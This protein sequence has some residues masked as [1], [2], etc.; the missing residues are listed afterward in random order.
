M[1]HLD[2]DLQRKLVWQF[3][4]GFL[5][6]LLLIAYFFF[7]ILFFSPKLLN[8][9]QYR[10]LL[11]FLIKSYRGWVFLETLRFWNPYR[12]L[13]WT[14]TKTSSLG[15]ILFTSVLGIMYDGKQVTLWPGWAGQVCQPLSDMLATLIVASRS[16]YSG[17]PDP[18]TAKF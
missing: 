10:E 8:P 2:S 5:L 11:N 3:G 15:L 14:L 4:W 18:V 7:E 16:C 9:S 13:C 6:L 12:G 17:Q 1:S